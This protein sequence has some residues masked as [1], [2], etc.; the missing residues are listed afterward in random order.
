MTPLSIRLSLPLVGALALAAWLIVPQGFAV[1]RWLAAEDDPVALS[2]LALDKAFDA[3]VARREIE[4][5]LTAGDVELAQSF[6]ALAEERNVPVDPAL[7]A[8]VRA[9]ASGAA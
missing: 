6:V 4:A 1:A 2:G 5:A 8:R 3:Q 9:Q 7:A